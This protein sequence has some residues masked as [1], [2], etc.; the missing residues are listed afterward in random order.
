MIHNIEFNHK[1]K[2]CEYP[3]FSYAYDTPKTGDYLQFMNICDKFY[4]SKEEQDVYISLVKSINK[5]KVVSS[6]NS[7]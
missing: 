2:C 4:C 6:K 1:D 7:F 3:T 5:F